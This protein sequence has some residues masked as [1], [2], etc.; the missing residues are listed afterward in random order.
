MSDSASYS[1]TKLVVHDLEA[2]ARYYGAVFGLQEIQRVKA[3]ID[4]SPIDEIILGLG[5]AYGG[6]I[7]LTWVGALPP[8]A[9]EVILGFTTADIGQLFERATAAGGSV[10]QRPHEVDAAPGFLV[11]FLTDPEGHLAE[12]VQPTSA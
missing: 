3:E 9:G 11:G 4:G 7:L 5:G 10:R 1:F 6:L 2:M 12:I 8:Q